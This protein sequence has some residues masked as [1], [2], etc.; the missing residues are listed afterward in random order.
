[1]ACYRKEEIPPDHDNHLIEL[2]E[3]GLATYINLKPL[4]VDSVT[5]LLL[6]LEIQQPNN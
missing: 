3:Q 1:M 6:S 2:A 5:K 4:D